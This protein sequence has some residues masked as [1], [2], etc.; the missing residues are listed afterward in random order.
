MNY[1]TSVTVIIR[2]FKTIYLRL[3]DQSILIPR[4]CDINHMHQSSAGTRTRTRQ[5]EMWGS[6]PEVNSTP[7]EVDVDKLRGMSLGF[8]LFPCWIYLRKHN[9]FAFSV[10]LQHWDDVGSWNTI[11]W[12]TMPGLLN[13]FDTMAADDLA[14]KSPGHQ[15]LWYWHS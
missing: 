3:Y 14:T 7:V 13:V 6:G 4:G 10:S 5:T 9:D 15:Q 12:K 8:W 2:E 11:W 1:V